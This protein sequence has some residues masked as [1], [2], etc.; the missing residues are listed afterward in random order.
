MSEVLRCNRCGVCFKTPPMDTGERCQNRTNLKQCHGRLIVWDSP[1]EVDAAVA[2]EVMGWEE[3]E[4][5][6]EYQKTIAWKTSWGSLAYYAWRP[7]KDIGDAWKTVDRMKALGFHCYITTH[8]EMKGPWE[9][10]FDHPDHD[11]CGSRQAGVSEAICRAALEAVRA[12]KAV[13]S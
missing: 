10:E 11:A 1:E 5:R 12:L 8:D 7:S 13:N 9:I 2:R 4:S 3:G 6:D